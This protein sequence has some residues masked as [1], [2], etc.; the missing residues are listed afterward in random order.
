MTEKQFLFSKK[1]L[2]S[3]MVKFFFPLL[4][5]LFTQA[6]AAKNITSPIAIFDPCTHEK[7]SSTPSTK[8]VVP[9]CDDQ[10]QHRLWRV[11]SVAR[12]FFVPYLGSYF[13]I[14]V[15]W[16]WRRDQ[17]LKV[18]TSIVLQSLSYQYYLW[19]FFV[20][21]EAHIMELSKLFV[22]LG[23]WVWWPFSISTF[24]KIRNF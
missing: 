17:F 23:W 7:K 15:L 22:L 2:F 10:W 4:P 11:R 6:M 13:Q 5:P 12:L 18:G 14:K 20:C 8:K 9:M 19:M 3:Y 21:G 24:F 1:Q 16:V